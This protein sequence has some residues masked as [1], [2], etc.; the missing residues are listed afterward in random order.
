MRQEINLLEQT[1]ARDYEH[2]VLDFKDTFEQVETNP[3]QPAPNSEGVGVSISTQEKLRR[4]CAVLQSM[5]EQVPRAEVRQLAGL[6]TWMA[7]SRPQRSTFTRMLW[8]ATASG[9]K[10]TIAARQVQAPLA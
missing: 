1:K 6:A 8:A 5:G 4:S 7:G 3:G 9:G 2:T 10:L